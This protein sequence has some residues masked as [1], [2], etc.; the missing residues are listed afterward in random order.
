MKKNAKTRK[1]EVYIRSDG[2]VFSKEGLERLKAG[3]HKGF[4][5]FKASTEAKFGGEWHRLCNPLDKEAAAA[6]KAVKG[7][8]ERG[9]FL[10]KA[11][12]AEAAKR[13][14]GT[15]KEVRGGADEPAEFMRITLTDDAYAVVKPM[16]NPEFRAFVSTAI[17]KA[18]K[19]R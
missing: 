16:A 15:V 5:R 14:K 11:I 12:V 2:W 7:F 13:A 4:E 8:V 6:L 19:R 9:A 17:L 18:A 10:S 3:G 1:S